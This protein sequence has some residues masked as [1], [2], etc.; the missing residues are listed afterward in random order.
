MQVHAVAK[1]WPLARATS[2]LS[3]RFLQ[4][5]RWMPTAQLPRDVGR[6]LAPSSMGNLAK[7][8]ST[9]SHDWRERKRTTPLCTNRVSVRPWAYRTKANDRRLRLENNQWQSQYRTLESVDGAP[10]AE[11]FVPPWSC[12]LPMQ[13]S[14]SLLRSLA[15]V[16]DSRVS[17]FRLSCCRHPSL[18]GKTLG[19]KKRR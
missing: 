3:P 9:R 4:I 18:Q 11:G 2:C 5:S 7:H 14:P 19:Y 8:S 15:V 10:Q 1:D 16:T 17:G 12:Y 13:A 6:P